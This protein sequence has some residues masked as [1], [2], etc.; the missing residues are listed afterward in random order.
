MINVA[1]TFRSA[2]FRPPGSKNAVPPTSETSES[3]PDD[4]EGR[5]RN[6]KQD[7]QQ[8]RAPT[9]DNGPQR[10][11][12]LATTSLT[13]PAFK[14]AADGAPL[15]IYNRR[16]GWERADLGADHDVDCRV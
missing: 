15:L 13:R 10:D 12:L 6:P 7:W 8:Q 14:D 3:N 5:R 1:P 9:N 16:G 11:S 4:E 2:H